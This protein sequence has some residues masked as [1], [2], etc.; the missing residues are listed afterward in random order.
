MAATK[1]TAAPNKR[2][3]AKPADVPSATQS[4]GVDI[5][6]PAVDANPRENTTAG[7]NKIDFNDPGLSGAEAVAKNLQKKG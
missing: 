6:H 3:P 1:K 4:T 7:Q 2:A 5:D